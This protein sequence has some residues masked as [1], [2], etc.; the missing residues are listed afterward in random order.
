MTESLFSDILP[1]QLE[2]T[3]CKLLNK[4]LN[5]IN[6]DAYHDD[7]NGPFPAVMERGNEP[8]TAQSAIALLL[9]LLAAVLGIRYSLRA[10]CLGKCAG[11]PHAK[12]C[13]AKKAASIQQNEM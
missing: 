6:L 10:K 2:K 5:G 11:C 8:M 7:G 13:A 3:N 9:F 12:L 4:R 1:L